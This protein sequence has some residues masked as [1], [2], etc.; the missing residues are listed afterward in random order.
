VQAIE[1]GNAV[2][3]EHHRLAIDHELPVAVLARAS[4]IHAKAVGPVVAAA[5]DQAYAVAVALQV[6][7]IANYL[8]SWK[9]VGAVGTEAAAVGRQNSKVLCI[10]KR[11]ACSHLSQTYLGLISEIGDFG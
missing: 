10:G 11:C 4:A 6:L 5:G 1:I 7:P 9:P 3:P 2:D 8:T